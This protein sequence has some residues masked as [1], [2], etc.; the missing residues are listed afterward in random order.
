MTA[1]IYDFIAER[2]KRQAAKQAPRQLYIVKAN[3][4]GIESLLADLDQEILHCEQ[5]LDHNNNDGKQ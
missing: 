1:Q 4:A 2:V 5:F 3:L